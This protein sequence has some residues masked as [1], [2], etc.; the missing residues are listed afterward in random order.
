[1]NVC[2]VVGAFAVVI[3]LL[4]FWDQWLASRERMSGY[5]KYMLDYFRD[6]IKDSQ[7]YTVDD[8]ELARQLL[9]N[10][11]VRHSY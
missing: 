5:R 11:P 6:Y 9:M 1:M 3:I 8:Y 7:G 10:Q 2:W 4:I